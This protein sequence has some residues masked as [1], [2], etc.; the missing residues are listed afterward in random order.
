MDDGPAQIPCG[1]HGQIRVISIDLHAQT[2]GGVGNLYADGSQTDDAQLLPHDLRSG[3]ILFL[4]LRRLGN[5][6]I[7]LRCLHPFDAAHHV[8]GRQKHTCDH[9]LLHAVGICAGG[10]KHHYTMFGTFVQGNIIDSRPGSGHSQQTLRQLHIMHGGASHQNAVRL[11][12]VG[13]NLIFLA[14]VL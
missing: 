5:I 9:Q 7:G 6:L 1:I 14:E 2:D 13:G 4:F 8:S 3:K 12:Y 11:L 10:I